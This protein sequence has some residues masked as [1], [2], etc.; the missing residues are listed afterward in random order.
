IGDGRGGAVRIDAEEGVGGALQPVRTARARLQTVERR[1]DDRH[2]RHARD[3]TPRRTGGLGGGE[4]IGGGGGGAVRGDAGGS[5]GVGAGHGTEGGGHGGARGGGGG[6]GRPASARLGH[7]EGA[8]GAK[9][10]PAGVVQ[11]GRQHPQVGS[12]AP[13]R[14]TNQSNERSEA[15][16]L[17]DA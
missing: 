3:Q 11:A 12:R 16:D 5:G 17:Q 10:Q 6:V 13:Q 8:I 4:G 14:P 2:P 1:A 9:R 7:V 15:D